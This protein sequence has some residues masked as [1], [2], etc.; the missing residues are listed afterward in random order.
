MKYGIFVSV[1][2][3]VLLSAC[4]SAEERVELAEAL[5]PGVMDT[6]KPPV[7]PERQRLGFE[8]IPGVAGS[9]QNVPSAGPEAYTYHFERPEGWEELPATQFRQINL[10]VAEAPDSEVYLSVL[11]GG[12]GGLLANLNR[13]RAQMGL[14]PMTE[15]EMNALPTMRL[16]GG[17]ALFVDLDGVYGGMSGELNHPEF[18]LFGLAKVADNTGY[19]VKMTGPAAVLETERD[20]FRAFTA[21]IHSHAPGE[22]H[23]HGAS[24]APAATQETP[25]EADHGHAH[26]NGDH[27]HDHDH[28]PGATSRAM[29]DITALEWEA[30]AGWVKAPD[31]AMRLVTYTSVSGASEC[32]ISALPGA[33]GGMEANLNRWRGQMGQEPLSSEAIAALPKVEVLGQALP[34]IE[35]SG[36][37]TDMA[38]TVHEN[39]TL[40]G[41]VYPMGIQ[42]LFVRMTGPEADMQAEREN[43]IAFCQSLQ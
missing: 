2:F 34:L 20:N 38:G 28:G 4:Y 41:V 5:P 23:D 36:D 25:A 9:G 6:R 35:I 26:D 3:A 37:F 30:P 39:Q 22:S 43:F 29:L 40:L 21:S 19:F 1:L 27:D 16:L 8:R 31:R 10:R 12:G 17:D 15:Q 42:T 14:E 11:P 24:P 13:W 33:A 7:L 18:K 32:Y